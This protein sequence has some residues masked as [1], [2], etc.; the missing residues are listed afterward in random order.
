MLFFT[1]Y[2]I[3]LLCYCYPNENEVWQY[4]LCRITSAKGSNDNIISF[5]IIKF[6]VITDIADTKVR[7]AVGS[8]HVTSSPQLIEFNFKNLVF[9]Q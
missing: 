2:S 9:Y 7:L 6:T 3:V 4:I 8:Q 5:A 1:F